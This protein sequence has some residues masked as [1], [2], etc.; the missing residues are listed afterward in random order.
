MKYL[1]DTCICIYYINGKHPQVISNLHKYS[2]AD[3]AISTITKGEMYA[4]SARSQIPQRSRAKQDNF[5]G[6][7]ICLPFDDGAAHHY[8]DMYAHLKR[9][10]NLIGVCDLQIAAIAMANN[11][12]VVTH[13][14]DDFGRIPG[15]T[16]EDWTNI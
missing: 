9:S 2:A 16:I 11:L 8:G 7:F 4:G 12:T 6:R 14:I 3:I 5:F 10:G 13:D 1:L 15:L